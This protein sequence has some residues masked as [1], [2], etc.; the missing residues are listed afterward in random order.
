MEIPAYEGYGRTI[1]VRFRC[2]RCKVTADRQL[3][4]C[5]P[6]GYAIRNLSDLAAPEGW[7]DGGFY[8][9]TLCKECAEKYDKFMNGEEYDN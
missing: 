9:P 6:N 7:Y 1:M 5:R 8:Y 2:Q 4:D 3:K